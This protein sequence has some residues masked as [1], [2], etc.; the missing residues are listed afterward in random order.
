MVSVEFFVDII[1]PAALWPWDRQKRVPGI[2][3]GGK[4]SQCIELTTLPPSC[5]DC[6]EIWEPQ[7]PGTLRASPDLWWNC[8]TLYLEV[9]G[10]AVQVPSSVKWFHTIVWV[11]R[12]H[13]EWT[14]YIWRH[15]TTS[16]PQLLFLMQNIG[17]KSLVLKSAV[18]GSIYC[19]LA[20]KQNVCS[21]RCLCP[22]KWWCSSRGAS[23]KPA[24]SWGG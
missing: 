3:P 17:L 6:F 20:V 21:S 1:L 23:V 2:F 10:Y 15:E 8:F 11:D 7:P 5:A 13:N 12:G 14:D 18:L 4:G 19:I 16:Q 24:S 9:M 22:H